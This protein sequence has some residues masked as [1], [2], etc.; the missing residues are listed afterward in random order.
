MAGYEADQTFKTLLVRFAVVEAQREAIFQELRPLVVTY[1][2]CKESFLEKKSEE[3]VLKI[4]QEAISV[5]EYNVVNIYY[6]IKGTNRGKQSPEQ[7]MLADK[8]RWIIARLKRWHLKLANMVWPELPKLSS[9]PTPTTP[10]VRPIFVGGGG[11]TSDV[12]ADIQTPVTVELFPTT[13]VA[14][15]SG[16]VVEE[17]NTVQNNFD[18]DDVIPPSVDALS[19][20][21]SVSPFNRRY[22]AR[23]AEMKSAIGENVVLPDLY[24]T[25]PAD[26]EVVVSFITQFRE[27]IIL[28]P[29]CGYGAFGQVLKANGFYSV[30][31]TDLFYGDGQKS[32]FLTDEVPDYDLLITNPP[33][34]QKKEFL[35]RAYSIGKPFV[36]LLPL[37]TLAYMGTSELF[38]RYGVRVLVFRPFI[39]DFLKDGKIK[40]KYC[41]CAYFLGNFPDVGAGEIKFEYYNRLKIDEEEA[42][43]KEEASA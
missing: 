4:F 34:S 14:T 8:A 43:G 30:V 28:D 21:S 39:S 6:E 24:T 42:E 22:S 37:D 5:D 33:F 41:A 10:H 12:S 25:F 23:N 15:F 18:D 31:E 17:K 19:I 3:W 35:E 13:P 40:G 7:K 9:L 36:L 16:D 29:C 11:S 1:F 38:M 2:E 32:N 20:E 26:V 27:S